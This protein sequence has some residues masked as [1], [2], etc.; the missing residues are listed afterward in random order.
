MD[1]AMAAKMMGFVWRAVPTGCG[2]GAGAAPP[3]D[4]LINLVA[5]HLADLAQLAKVY[6]YSYFP[7]LTWLRHT[8]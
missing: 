4:R 7:S 5:I 3:R 1:C 6:E 2:A 8:A